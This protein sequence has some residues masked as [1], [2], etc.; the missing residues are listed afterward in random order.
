MQLWRVYYEDIGQEYRTFVPVHFSISCSHSNANCSL[1]SLNK[2]PLVKYINSSIDK[3]T[4]L[5]SNIYDLTKTSL[6]MHFAFSYSIPEKPTSLPSLTI[7]ATS[8][9]RVAIVQCSEQ[10]EQAVVSDKVSDC[11]RSVSPRKE[12]RVYKTLSCQDTICCT[13]FLK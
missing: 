1:S 9:S 4:E 13:L 2:Q 6:F 7:L 10:V 3:P 5:L 8:K 11:I 12:A